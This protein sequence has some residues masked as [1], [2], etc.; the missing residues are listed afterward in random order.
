MLFES[1]H[2]RVTAEHGTATLWLAFPG[3][4]VNALD[5]ARLR[6][7]DAALAAVEPFL[8]PLLPLTAGQLASF[9]NRGTARP[10]PVVDAL[11]PRMRGIDAMIAPARDD[12]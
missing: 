7:L 2:V 11:R 12:G 4:P 1:A 10:H 8:F 3:D 5:L 6:D 9:A